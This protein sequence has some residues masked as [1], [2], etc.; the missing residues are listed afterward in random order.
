MQV[1]T[2]ISFLG[3]N[4]GTHQ[5]LN[6]ITKNNTINNNTSNLLQFMNIP[7]IAFKGKFV[8]P[9]LPEGLNIMPKPYV[10]IQPK[11]VETVA[12]QSF[13]VTAMDKAKSAFLNM[14][15]REPSKIGEDSFIRCSTFPLVAHQQELP[16]VKFNACPQDPMLTPHVEEYTLNSDVKPGLVSERVIAIESDNETKV[17]PDKNG[18]YLFDLNSSEFNRANSFFFVSKVLNMYENYLGRKIPWAFDNNQL[19]V[20]SIP[21]KE[22]NAY[23]NR[24]KQSISLLHFDNKKAGERLYTAKMADVITHE[25]GHAVM[26]GLR[27]TYFTWGGHGGGIHEGFSDATAMLVAL[28][29]DKLVDEVIKQ[30]DGDLSKDNFIAAIAEQFAHFVLDKPHLRTSINEVK[31]SEFDSCRESKEVHNFGRLF[32]GTFNDLLVGM[33]KQNEKS[34]PIKQ[35]IV[36]TREDL[37][38]LL[39]RTV[40]DFSP[41][42]AI[43]FDNIA[44]SFMKAEEVDFK[45]KYKNLIRNVMLGREILTPQQ[46]KEWDAKQLLVPDL[47]LTSDLLTSPDKMV[48]YVN[49]N[50]GLFDVPMDNIYELDSIFT[51]KYGETFVNVKAP[52]IIDLAEEIFEKDDPSAE[53]C[54]VCIYDGLTLAFNANGDLFYNAKCYIHDYDLIFETFLDVKRTL[55]QEK[56]N[57]ETGKGY[58]PLVYKTASNLLVKAPI[59]Q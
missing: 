23:Y 52:R 51:N 57:Q 20:E 28:W 4:K 53:E 6:N 46:I 47:T 56:I 42:G 43:F 54:Q 22:P 3:F 58:G 48:Q 14:F 50:K 15:H 11:V 27:P 2:P 31:K 33:I 59:I 13:I 24:M 38:K 5:I 21:T 32:S 19:K 18:N 1:Q 34:M 35:A 8:I 44:E 55:A 17:L 45:G 30:T 41:V 37:T 16:V 40:G 49:K 26:D 29:N 10:N 25:A 12:P 7:D 36:R 9:E 39:I